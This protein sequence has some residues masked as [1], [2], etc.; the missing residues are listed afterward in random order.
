M[1]LNLMKCKMQK[2]QVINACKMSMDSDQFP[3]ED[4]GN[5]T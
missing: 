1:R 5:V 2:G 3:Q 4:N